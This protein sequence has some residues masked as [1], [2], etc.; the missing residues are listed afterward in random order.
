[1]AE[2]R[3]QVDHDGPVAPYEQVKH[4]VVEAVDAGVLVPGEKLPPV[5]TLAT[6]LGLAANTVARAYKELE[7]LGVVATRGR[8]G[9]VV[10]GANAGRSAREAAA[11]YVATVRALGVDRDE[12][13]DLVRRA[14][15]G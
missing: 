3:W 4:Q 8:A 5:R 1:M 15:E 9:T 2:P 7:A 13:L 14:Y 12:A 11:G 6:R 10:L